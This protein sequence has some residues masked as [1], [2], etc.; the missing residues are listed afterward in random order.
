MPGSQYPVRVRVEDPD[1]GKPLANVPVEIEFEI[2]DCDKDSEETTNKRNVTTDA[3]GYAVTTFQIGR[4]ITC[5]AGEVLA[6]AT[7]AGFSDFASTN[8]KLPDTPSLRVSTDKPLYQRGQT[9]HL[10]LLAFGPNKHV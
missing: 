1:T 2:S 9:V 5:S 3:S 4:V 7:R 6:T 8:F 10:R